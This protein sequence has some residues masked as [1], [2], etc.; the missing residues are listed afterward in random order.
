MLVG[1]YPFED[2]D[3][4][5]NFRKT[6]GRIMSVQYSIPAYVRISANCKQLLSQIFVANPAKRITIPEIKQHPWFLK[7]LP[8]EIIEIEKTN[9]AES[10]GDQPSQTIEEIKRIVQ[11]AKRPGEGVKVGERAF[12]GTSDDLEDDLEDEIDVS[13]D[14]GPIV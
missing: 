1:S 6:I 12:V 5:R 7:N 10:Q 3:D 11:E 4:P 8:K 13:G 14:I 2:P 9:Y